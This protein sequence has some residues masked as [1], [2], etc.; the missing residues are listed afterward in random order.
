MRQF[1]LLFVVTMP[2]AVSAQELPES[3]FVV[4]VKYT[5]VDLP[6][7]SS[8]TCL[9]VFPD[10]RFHMEQLSEW[11]S[12]GPRVFEESLSDESLKSLSTILETEELKELRTVETGPV[13]IAQGAIVWAAI[14]RGE[15]T[16]K[17]IFSAIEASGGHPPKPFPASLGPFVQWVQATTKALT[18]RNMRPLKNAKPVNC[19]L[20]AH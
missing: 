9:A 15:I 11:P 20:A 18:Q 10:G 1:A 2:L 7:S 19:W 3:S 8:S 17:L 4:K 14:P 16:Q 12:S 13:K 6:R 5:K